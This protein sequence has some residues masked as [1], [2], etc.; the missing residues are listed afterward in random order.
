MYKDK[1]RELTFPLAV[2][3][4]YHNGDR[5]K[6]GEVVRGYAACGLTDRRPKTDQTALSQAVSH[7][8]RLPAV[9]P[10]TRGNFFEGSCS[11]VAVR[12]GELLI[13]EPLGS[14]SVGGRRPPATGRARP[15]HAVHVHD[16]PRVNCS[17]TGR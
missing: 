13:E 6:T 1:E 16:L 3:L 15:A 5:G 17:R 14:A 2:C 4:S 8:N 9:P 12:G 11:A 7:R 10:S